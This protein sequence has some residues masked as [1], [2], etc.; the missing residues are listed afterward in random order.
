MTEGR[1]DWH[2]WNWQQ[3]MRKGTGRGETYPHQA[4]GGI[5]CYSSNSVSD[6]AY[7]RDCDRLAW[8]KDSVIDG[9]EAIYKAAIYSQLLNGPWT[10]P[11]IAL[12]PHFRMASE[13]VGR[14][15]DKKGIE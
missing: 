15:L 13:M 7:E 3:W 10:A 8:A 11:S 12:G 4:S 14:G 2:L 1:Q 9:L 5:Q 6:E